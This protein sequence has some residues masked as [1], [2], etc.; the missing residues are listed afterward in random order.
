MCRGAH[1]PPLHHHNPSIIGLGAPPHIS[2]HLCPPRVL[3]SLPPSLASPAGRSSSQLPQRTTTNTQAKHPTTVYVTCSE[4]GVFFPLKLHNFRTHDSRPSFLWTSD[5]FDP[6]RGV[7]AAAVPCA[8]EKAGTAQH[9]H[10]DAGVRDQFAC[11]GSSYCPRE[12]KVSA[13]GDRQTYRYMWSSGR[14]RN[15]VRVR[16]SSFVQRTLAQTTRFS[17]SFTHDGAYHPDWT[18]VAFSTS[19]LFR[20]SLGIG[21]IDASSTPVSSYVHS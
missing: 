13:Q 1:Q 3:R 18:H 7:Q 6:P 17:V 4:N 16:K 9:G 12:D 15:R 5:L 21:S 14:R 8:A 19:E 11:H 20:M 2:T 10:V